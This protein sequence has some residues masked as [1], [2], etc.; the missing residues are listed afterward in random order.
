MV[1]EL[2]VAPSSMHIPPRSLA[3][4]SSFGA[5]ALI[6]TAAARAQFTWNG[7]SS[8]DSNWG[9]GANWVGG[10]A[11]ST[12]GQALIFAGTVRLAP[13]VNTPWSVTSITVNSGAG[14][15]VIGGSAITLT[16]G[17]GITNNASSGITFSAAI[18][19]GSTNTTFSPSSATIT[20]NGVLSGSGRVVK[21]GNGILAI[22][23]TGN[24]G[25]LTGGFTINAGTLQASASSNLLNSRLGQDPASAVAD[26]FLFNGGRFNVTGVPANTIGANKGITLDTGGGTI[27]LS[28]PSN[29]TTYNGVITGSGALQLLNND[30]FGN[31]VLGGANT[32]TGATTLSGGTL[33][34]THADALQSSTLTAASTG[35]LKFGTVSINTTAVNLGGLAGAGN[36]A[37]VNLFST[38]SAVSLTVGANGGSTTYSGALSA[39]GGL[40]KTGVGTLTLSGANSYTGATVVENGV[41]LV[42]GSLAAGSTLT[43]ASGGT[44]GGAGAVN[45]PAT[46]SS[47]GT[48]SPG[49]GAGLLSFGDTLTL[50][51]GSTS[52]FQI[53]GSVRGSGYDAV[54][55]A[56]PATYGGTLSLS[57]GASLA[58]GTTLHLFGLG[59]GRSGFLGAVSGTGSYAGSFV[60]ESGVWTLSRGAQSLTF[61]ESTGDLVVSAIPEPAICAALVGAGALAFVAAGRRRRCG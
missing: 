6:T 14:S 8:S 57:F 46:I 61:T 9:T 7:G 59:G 42:D 43:V 51:N 44:L 39:S 5:L 37:L 22:S 10:T 34:L 11:P 50:A 38:P 41:L 25:V 32:F 48:L 18:S 47:G 58:D 36:I 26:Y 16:G 15:F 19:F 23:N 2:P 40:T 17:G 56:G 28:N 52:V 20:L 13:I 12:S 29:I 1:T 21:T 49:S 3:R 4:L 33:T 45:G 54:D 27:A 35:S 53:N 24:S 60:N 30:N 31:F 55:V